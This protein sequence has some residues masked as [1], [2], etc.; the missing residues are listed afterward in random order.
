MKNYFKY[1]LQKILGF[2]NYLFIFSLIKI[3]TL[4]FDRKENDFLY[5]LNMIPNHGIVL[6]IGANIG[7][8]TVKLAKRLPHTKILAF[9]PV[10]HNLHALR[11]I[12]AYYKLNNVKIFDYAL[13]NEEGKVK[14]VMPVLSSVKMQGLSHVMHKSITEFNEGETFDVPIYKLD[15]FP[16]LANNPEPISA[17]KLDVENFEYFVLK[18]G[19]KRIKKDRPIIYTELWKNKNRTDCINFAKSLNYSVKVF[20]N[21]TLVDFDEEKHQTQNF[22]FIP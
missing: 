7:I 9:E 20:Q 12:T 8:M 14:M 5:F 1:I 19:E 17:I 6:D 18:G 11:K 2:E 22:F 13:G 3:K 15:T 21:K 4:E 10:H 16:E